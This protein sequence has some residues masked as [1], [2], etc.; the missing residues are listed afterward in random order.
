[1]IVANLFEIFGSLFYIFRQFLQPELSSFVLGMGTFL[2]WTSL[3]QYVQT[4]NNFYSI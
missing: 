1:M 4:S 3:M 2:V